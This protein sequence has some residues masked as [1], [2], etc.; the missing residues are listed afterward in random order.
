MCKLRKKND[1][2]WDN[3]PEEELIAELKLKMEELNV[4][5]SNL[6]INKITPKGRGTPFLKLTFLMSGERRDAT[7]RLNSAKLETG[8][9]ISP[10]EPRECQSWLPRY[11][12]G[13]R[14]I[15]N[16]A[17]F[18]CHLAVATYTLSKHVKC[19]ILKPKH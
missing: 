6:A 5:Q 16:I 1:K 2:T 17:N 14:N 10:V 15:I 11:K 4:N 19:H 8:Y 3:K 12:T 18:N 7:G 9:I 13:M